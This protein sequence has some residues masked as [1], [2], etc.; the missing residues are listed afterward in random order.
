MGDVRSKGMGP[1]NTSSGLENIVAAVL[2]AL[3]GD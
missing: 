3:A 1:Q 2:A